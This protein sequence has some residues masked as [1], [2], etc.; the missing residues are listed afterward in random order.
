MATIGLFRLLRPAAWANNDEVRMELGTW[1][2]AE[3]QALLEPTLGD[4]PTRLAYD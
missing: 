4:E 1:K 3:W 2:A